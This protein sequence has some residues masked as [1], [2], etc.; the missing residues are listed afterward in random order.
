[1]AL[2]HFNL[3]LVLWEQRKTDEAIRECRLALAANPGVAAVCEAVNDLEQV[4]K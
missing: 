3:D 1:M 4:Q 2:A